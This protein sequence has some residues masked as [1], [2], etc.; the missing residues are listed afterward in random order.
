M[1]INISDDSFSPETEISACV[2]DCGMCGCQEFVFSKII[3][4]INKR[5]HC[6]YVPGGIEA[7]VKHVMCLL[8]LVGMDLDLLIRK[9]TLLRLP[10]LFSIHHR[11]PFVET[12]RNCP[13]FEWVFRLKSFKI[14]TNTSTTRQPSNLLRHE[15][16]TLFMWTFMN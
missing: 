16:I 10:H 12:S 14:K 2:G 3:I 15:V 11:S 1:M 6:F 4:N 7:C 13:L 9:V 8:C 5:C